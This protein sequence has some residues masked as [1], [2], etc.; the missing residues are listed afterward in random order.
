LNEHLEADGPTSSARQER[1][2]EG[3]S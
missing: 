2:T 1:A 3:V